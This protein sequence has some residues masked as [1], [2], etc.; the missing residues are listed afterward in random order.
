MSAHDEMQ[1]VVGAETHIG[2]EQIGRGGEQPSFGLIEARSARDEEPCRDQNF[3]GRTQ[4]IVIGV[5]DEQAE[6]HMSYLFRSKVDADFWPDRQ[7]G[8]VH[9]GTRVP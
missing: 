9:D 8:E 5:D 1:A 2:D 6:R 7:S 4:T 3:F